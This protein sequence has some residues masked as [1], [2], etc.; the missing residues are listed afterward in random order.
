MPKALS[1]KPEPY[2]NDWTPAARYD[3]IFTG[4]AYPPSDY[5]KWGE[6]VFQ[7]TKHCVG[8]YG[9]AEVETWYWEVWNEANISYWKGSAEGFQRLHDYAVDG[10]R[11]ALPSA[12]VGGPDCAGSGGDWTRGF[13]EHCLRGTNY[14]TGEVGT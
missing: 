14:A 12:R 6:L 3:E 11:R 9:R 8:R 5:A 10:I 13:L 1:V 2:Q 4:W 7:W